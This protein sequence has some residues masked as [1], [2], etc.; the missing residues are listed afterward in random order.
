MRHTLVEEF[1]LDGYLASVLG[2][3]PSLSDEGHKVDVILNEFKNGILNRPEARGELINVLNELDVP[4]LPLNHIHAVA[5]G[6]YSVI[7]VPVESPYV[8]TV[9]INL[10]SNYELIMRGSFT[11]G[12]MVSLIR[13]VQSSLLKHTSS[14]SKFYSESYTRNGHLIWYEIVPCTDVPRV[15]DE[16]APLLNA[17]EYLPSP[18]A[19]IFQVYAY[20][21]ETHATPL[22]QE[23]FTE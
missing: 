22:T 6:G 21:S 19:R 9:G 7:Q 23:L 12:M 10:S 5:E 13:D 15:L 11:T 20:E 2:N 18:P 16:L 1:Q 8:Y 14:T 3:L 17:K 4:N